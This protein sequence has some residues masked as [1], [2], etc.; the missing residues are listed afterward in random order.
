[1][2]SEGVPE[3]LGEEAVKKEEVRFCAGCLSML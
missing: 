3:L 1:M 2:G